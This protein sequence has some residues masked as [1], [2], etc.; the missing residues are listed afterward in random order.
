MFYFYLKIDQEFQVRHCPPVS[1]DTIAEWED[2]EL[3]GPGPILDNLQFDWMAGRKSAW[4]TKTI[5]LL[6]AVVK[7]ESEARWTHIPSY[8]YF[9]WEESVWQKFGSL[10]T[11]WKSGQQK[12]IGPT[13]T[14]LESRE[15]VTRRLEEKRVVRRKVA[16]QC[17]RRH[18]VS[19]SPFQYIVTLLTVLAEICR[20]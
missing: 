18:T 7:A 11:H 17:T 2:K 4:N 9:Y 14:D 8:E 15:A 6:T 5:E 3:Q 12:C 1:Q 10:A 13:L 20:S 19:P 16:R